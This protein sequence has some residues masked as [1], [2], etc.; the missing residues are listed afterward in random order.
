MK[1]K[2][3]DLKAKDVMNKKV[4]KILAHANLMELRTLFRTRQITGVPV[5]D[6]YGKL[7]GVISETDLVQADTHRSKNH[8]GDVHDYFKDDWQS[9]ETV[10]D[11]ETHGLETDALQ[12]KTVEELMT[13]WVVSAAEETPLTEIA[14]QMHQEHVHRILIINQKKCLTGIVTSM[15]IVKA[16]SQLNGKKE[17]A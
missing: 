14:K 13:P 2:I 9:Q 10:M 7:I 1:S 12:E 3:E 15:D 16:V 6:D 8:E 17:K 4:I 11:F 5:I